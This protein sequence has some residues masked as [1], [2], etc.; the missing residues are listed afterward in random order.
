MKI[1]QSCSYPALSFNIFIVVVIYL[2]YQCNTRV[3]AFQ[4]TI[5][6]NWY[7]R[8]S[9][10]LPSVNRQIHSSNRANCKQEFLLSTTI[11]SLVQDATDTNTR[12]ISSDANLQ[13]IG[14]SSDSQNQ[15]IDYC[16]VNNLSTLVNILQPF[17]LSN[18]KS[19]QYNYKHSGNREIENHIVR[20]GQ[21]GRTEE[22]LQ[23][24]FAIHSLDRIRNAYRSKSM[25]LESKGKEVDSNA[26]LSDITHKKMGWKKSDGE[27]RELSQLRK[28]LGPLKNVRPT[29]RL[30]NLAIDACARANPVRQDMAFDLFHMACVDEKA[31]SPNV[32]TFGSLLASCARN[33]DIDTS[34][35][36]LHELEDGKYLDVVPND[37]IYSTVISACERKAAASSRDESGCSDMVDLA[38]EVLNNATLAL[39]LDMTIGQ[40]SEE[41]EG[42]G[43]VGFN[44]AISTLA[45]ATEWRL[46]V[47]LLSEMI[48]HS[49]SNS[50]FDKGFSLELS[51][52]N[53]VDDALLHVVHKE[54]YSHR[55]F[56][57]PKPDE[58]SFGSVLAACERAGEWE[59]LLRVANSGK[60][61]GVRLDGIALTS[62]LHAC[63]QLG[64][65][66]EAL[67]YL[68]LMKQLGSAAEDGGNS[69]SNSGGVSARRT[70]GRMRK[71]AKQAL[72]GPDGVAYRLAIS[73]CARSP[74]RYHDCLRL[75]DDMRETAFQSNSTDNAPDVVS[76]KFTLCIRPDLSLMLYVCFNHGR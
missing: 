48:A 19:K 26:L 9:G 55:V 57:I 74:G 28:I 71:G 4:S 11:A 36:L 29:T 5:H 76:R 63:Q 17:A 30:L 7:A 54:K 62:A 40:N 66:D 33:R 50:R 47:Q 24:Y 10:N 20:L 8:A 60:E 58:V 75:L 32:F 72:R 3:E 52:A 61:Y 41:G 16:K 46:A 49:N 69:V 38:L 23:L 67:E 1:K 18:R 44:A 43:V 15:S 70:N 34:L 22:A 13:K 14:K 35:H 6:S 65:A 39:S 53:P 64:L 45:R 2:A 73:A 27:Q 25:S 59:E 68:N 12:H 56:F 37:V 42:I 21:K 51:C 31:I